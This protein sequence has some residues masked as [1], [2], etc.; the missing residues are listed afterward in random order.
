MN[1]LGT[2][3]MR[4]SAS[5]ALALRAVR[6]NK[7]RAGLT[8]LGITIGVAAV[9]TVMALARGAREGVMAQVNALGSNALIVFPRSSRTS[10]ARD[11]SGS[12]LSETDVKA[13]LRE[14]TSI[15]AAVPFLRATALAV[16]EGENAST[17]V[18]GTRL[19]YF[20]IRNWKPMSGDV[21]TPSAESVGDKVVL[22]GVETARKLFGS[23]DPVGRNVRI[24][25]FYYRILGVLEEKG[26]SPFG[27]NQDEIIVMPISTMRGTIVRTR[28]NEVHAIMFNA[29]SAET[30]GQA[31]R[32]AELI[33]RD[34]HR[35]PEGMDDDFQVLSQAEFQELQDKIFGFLTLLLIGVAGVSLLVGG[36]GVMNI[37]LVSVAERTREIGIRMAIGAREADILTQFLIESLVLALIG[38]A[39]G[40]FLGWLAIYGF[41][42]ALNWQIGLDFATLALALGTSSTIG[43]VFGFLPARRAA[44]LDP[45]KALGRE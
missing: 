37:M 31:K 2:L 27:Q 7:L 45:I 21:W 32:Q 20:T 13:L 18:I 11:S 35:I 22:I 42:R 38:G 6:R 44:R 41:G 3:I 19:D 16:Y 9:V 14:S 1:L 12:K 5:L 28:P 34:R 24:G 25:R 33:L 39:L 26:Q 10:G 36:I 4:L 30:S 40:T 8:T 43:L 29:T 15:E 17:S 23:L